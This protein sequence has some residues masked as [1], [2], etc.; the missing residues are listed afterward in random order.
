MCRLPNIACAPYTACRP[1]LECI[2]PINPAAEAVELSAYTSTPL[3][4]LSY[5]NQDFTARLQAKALGQ[6]LCV[7]EDC[8]YQ[9]DACIT[10][11]AVSLTHNTT[12][13]QLAKSLPF[14]QEPDQEY[15][16]DGSPV[17]DVSDFDSTLDY[18]NSPVTGSGELQPYL[19][20]YPNGDVDAVLPFQS[21]CLPRTYCRRC[22][23]IP[24]VTANGA[25]SSASSPSHGSAEAS[26]PAIRA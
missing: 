21:L 22:T 16:A 20:R 1:R 9:N 26:V 6:S 15:D 7:L 2:V 10:G 4:Q 18:L 24:R 5:L 14:Q 3:N 8:D 23:Q 17:Y 12:Y 13:R 11:C 19:P 25:Y